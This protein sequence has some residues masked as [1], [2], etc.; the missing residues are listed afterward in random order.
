MEMTGKSG[1]EFAKEYCDLIV[2]HHKEVVACLR[3]LPKSKN[4]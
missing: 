4:T 3:G 2:K 1:A